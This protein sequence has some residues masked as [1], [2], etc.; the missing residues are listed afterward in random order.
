MT[1][2]LGRRAADE[3]AWS[4]GL[5][6]PLPDRPRRANVLAVQTERLGRAASSWSAR[7][8]VRAG[9]AVTRRPSSE[10]AD[11]EDLRVYR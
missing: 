1:L 6:H 11:A 7:G 10:L 2:H 9:R 8:G 4:V 3:N 5:N